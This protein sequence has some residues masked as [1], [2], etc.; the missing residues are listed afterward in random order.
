MS[1]SFTIRAASK[2]LALAAVAAELDKVVE[3]DPVHKVD[4]P[5][6]QHVAELMVGLLP[7]DD[8]R[9][10]SVAMNG[11]V[12]GQ[13]QGERPLTL[14]SVNVGCGAALVHRLS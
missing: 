10:V 7:D 3:R 5:Q 9:D 11:Y 14:S 8:S 1:Y 6:A 2:A 13:L 12:T 4:R